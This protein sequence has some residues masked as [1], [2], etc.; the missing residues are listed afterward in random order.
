[1]ILAAPAL[2]LLGLHLQTAGHA[3]RLIHVILVLELGWVVG[4]VLPALDPR[5]EVLFPAVSLPA[6]LVLILFAWLARD[7]WFSLES[8][9]RSTTS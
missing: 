6:V 1:M 8:C 9:P 5:L 4:R 3:L 7:T 2:L